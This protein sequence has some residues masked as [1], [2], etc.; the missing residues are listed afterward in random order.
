MLLAQDLGSGLGS[1]LG[2]SFGGTC[3]TV[4]PAKLKLSKTV[5]QAW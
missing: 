4:V 2:A 3:A 1:D 5:M